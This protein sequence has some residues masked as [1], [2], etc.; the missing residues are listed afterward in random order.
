MPA[1]EPT[2]A[3][4]V[5]PSPPAPQTGDDAQAGQ[6]AGG[7]KIVKDNLPTVRQL[8]AEG[9]LSVPDMHLDI[10]VFSEIPAER[11]VF[12]NMRRYTEG[13]QLK[14]GPRVAQITR[15]GVILDQNGQRFILTR[16]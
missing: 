3:P 7:G 4:V 2:P 13:A 8:V 10:H 16:D 9:A 15:D 12:I 5:S 6:P 14:E 11:F 1:I